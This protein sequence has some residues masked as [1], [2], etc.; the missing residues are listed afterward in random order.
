MRPGTLAG[1]LD[2]LRGNSNRNVAPWPGY[3]AG[4]CNLALREYTDPRAEIIGLVDAYGT[5]ERRKPTRQ[6]W[7]RRN[8]SR[9]AS[10]PRRTARPT[11]L[12]HPRS[13]QVPLPSQAIHVSDARSQGAASRASVNATPHR[14]ATTQH[15]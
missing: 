2:T 9:R 11:L 12:A 13:D 15:E 10:T 5:A 7:R 14:H 3:K 6:A 4:A 8:G 1:S